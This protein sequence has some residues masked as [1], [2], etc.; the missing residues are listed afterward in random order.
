MET[1]IVTTNKTL[2]IPRKLAKLYGIKKGVEI[3][4]VEERDHIKIFPITKEVIDRNIGF[5]GTNGKLLK[6]LIKEKRL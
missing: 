1:T 2:E 5:L 6:A 4:F 3:H